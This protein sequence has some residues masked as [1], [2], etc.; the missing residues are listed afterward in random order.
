MREAV[1]AEL[2]IVLTESSQF[3]VKNES[4]NMFQKQLI[5]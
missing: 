1:L 4:L 3:S 2:Q 5:S